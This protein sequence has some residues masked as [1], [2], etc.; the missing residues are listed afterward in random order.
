MPSTH[1]CFEDAMP[2]EFRA[3]LDDAEA[4]AAASDRAYDLASVQAWLCPKHRALERD[5]A[6]GALNATF[7]A[8]A[9]ASAGRR[10]DPVFKLG[11]RVKKLKGW[12]RWLVLRLLRSDVRRYS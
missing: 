3:W 9:L 7:V 6:S 10:G 11:L 8:R 2:A 4:E 12:R 1:E 5:L